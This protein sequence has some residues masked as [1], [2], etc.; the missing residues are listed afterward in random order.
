P[1]RAGTAP[2]SGPTATIVV[3]SQLRQLSQPAL[4][5]GLPPQTYTDARFNLGRAFGWQIAHELAH[6]FGLFDEYDYQT[7]AQITNPPPTFLSTSDVLSMSDQEL[8]A[9]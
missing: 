4:P 5:P 6:N 9:L 7:L 8:R 2:G 1:E 3:D